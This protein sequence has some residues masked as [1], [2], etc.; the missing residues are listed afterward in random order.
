VVALR[1][2]LLPDGS[3][4]PEP[5]QHR[6]EALKL[7]ASLSARHE[8]QLCRRRRSRHL[9]RSRRFLDSFGV[10]LPLAITASP[11]DGGVV[12]I[13]AILICLLMTSS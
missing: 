11:E 12:N 6:R 7:V 4:G 10:N 2:V 9:R 5:G 8:Q 3:E 13:P 1:T